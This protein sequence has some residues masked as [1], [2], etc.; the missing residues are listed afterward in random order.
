VVCSARNYAAAADIVPTDR[1]TLLPRCHFM[2]GVSAIF[3]ALL[4]GAC[5]LPFDVRRRGFSDLRSWLQAERITVY[6]SVPTLF[7][8]FCESLSR[9]DMFPAIRLVKLGGE[10]VLNND[11]KLWKRHFPES[12]VFVNGLGL[13]EAVGNLCHF[14]IRHDA[15]ADFRIVPVGYPLPGVDILLLGDDGHP[16]P[17]GEIGEIAFRCPHR[18]PGYWRSDEFAARLVRPGI[19][20]GGEPYFITG[21]LGRFQN[22]DCLE[23]LGRKDGLLK[24]RGVRIEPAQVEAA[25]MGDPRI[26]ECA[27]GLHGEGKRRSW[28][29]PNCL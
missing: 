26:R 10:C 23:H 29:C 18:S 6:H 17:A 15:R 9:G 11:V 1:M 21:D 14:R 2:A 3:G 12:S 25:L 7:R 4:N 24:L 5:L 20:D 13:T 8:R 27:V 22:G 16:V 19:G 28:P